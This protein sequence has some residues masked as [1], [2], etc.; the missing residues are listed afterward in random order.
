MSNFQL[1]YFNVIGYFDFFFKFI[2]KGY[3]ED[4]VGQIIIDKGIVKFEGNFDE[5]VKIFID[6]VVKCWSE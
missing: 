1:E 5:F 2:L 4:V 6:F 3:V